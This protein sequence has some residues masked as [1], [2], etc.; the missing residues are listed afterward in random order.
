M[1]AL[2]T[3]AGATP[4]DLH[5]IWRGA[6]RGVRGLVLWDE[7]D[8]IVRPDAS[9]GPR[10]AAYA[11]VFKLLRGE[12]GR[13]L[14]AAEPIL[15]P[16]AVLYSPVSFRVRW[17][18]D[19]RP[20]GNAWMKRSAETEGGDN[21]FRVALRDTVAALARMGLRP[22]FVTPEQ[23][24][25]GPPPERALIL[26]QTLA[27]SEREIAAVRRFAARGGRM[28]ADV[29]PGSFDGHGRRRAAAPSIPATI[30]AP[31][32]LAK[33]LTVPPAFR[34]EAPEGDVDT[35]LFRSQ[36]RRLLALHRRAPG[37]GPEAV[38]E[39]VIVHL[40]GAGAR[41]LVTGQVY[42]GAERLSLT[43]GPVTPAFLEIIP[44]R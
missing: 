24:A 25:S 35:Y 44:K 18:L 21:A 11:P 30:A 36:G 5:A 38:P 1:V 20:E 13:R 17:M 40:N 22:R 28:I 37:A 6:L 12:I 3:S 4:A 23:L 39:E 42:G 41:D 27:L 10:A 14:V 7:D 2:A 9:L 19:H 34:V 29:P 16:V 26:P 43:L 31:A 32:D 8:G 15:D 33:V